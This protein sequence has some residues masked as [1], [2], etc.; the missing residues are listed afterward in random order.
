MKRFR[1]LLTLALILPGLLIATGC[2]KKVT[3]E[4]D[5]S[6]GEYY[7]QDE[8]KKLDTEQR[9]EYCADLADELAR[10]QDQALPADVLFHHRYRRHFHLLSS[11]LRRLGS[12]VSPAALIG[13]RVRPRS[14]RD[15]TGGAWPERAAPVRAM[16]ISG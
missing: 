15:G 4:V 8:F 12:L 16:G 10:L 3:R 11:L 1:I 7:T 9:D 13:L 2:G 14:E 6:T 5:V